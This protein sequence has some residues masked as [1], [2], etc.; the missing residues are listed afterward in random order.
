MET[1]TDG[2]MLFNQVSQYS[3]SFELNIIYNPNNL[4]GVGSRRGEY[5]NEVRNCSL[6]YSVI[7]IN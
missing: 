6:L 7:I 1:S 4:T 3:S 5:F 2:L